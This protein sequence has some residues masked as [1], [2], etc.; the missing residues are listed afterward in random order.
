MAGRR[1]KLASTEPENAQPFTG[2]SPARAAG[3]PGRRG[4]TLVELLVVISI[5][6]L[7]VALLLPAISAARESARKTHCRSNLRQLGQAIHSYHAAHGMF[8]PSQFL[9]PYGKGPDSKAWSWMAKLLPFIEERNLYLQGKV[10]SRSL[11][12]SQIA[13][14]RIA[15][16]LCPSDPFSGDEAFLDAGD[17]PDFAAGHTNYQAVSGAN[18]GHDKSQQSEDIG[19]DWANPG[20]N[21]SQDGL[22][23]G[24]GPMCRSDVIRPRGFR[25]LSDGASRTFLVGEQLPERNKW[26]AWPYA[27]GAHATCAIPP[28]VVPRPGSDYSPAWWPNVGGFR[29]AHAG[30]LHFAHADASVR[31]LADE[32]DLAAYR[33]LATIAGRENLAA[34]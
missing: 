34:E 1:G 25:H 33:A 12:E 30:G 13:A 14:G 32:V 17:L 3:I 8:P 27:N 23:E 11:R 26:C 6:A 22:A 29:S 20:K 24:D 21:G 18:W 7:L 9:G 16:L 19:T 4:F 10:P 5:V 2:N 15:L 28:N 31:W